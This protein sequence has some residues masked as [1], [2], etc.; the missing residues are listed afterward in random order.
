M[1][2]TKFDE[3]EKNINKAIEIKPNAPDARQLLNKLKQLK[4]L[5]NG[6]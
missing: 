4:T 2:Y 5:S 1:N 3:A 6:N